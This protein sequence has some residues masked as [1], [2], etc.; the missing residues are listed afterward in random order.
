MGGA[1]GAKAAAGP[2]TETTVVNAEGD[3]EQ[4]DMGNPTPDD[5]EEHHDALD[6]VLR[7]FPVPGEPWVHIFGMANYYSSLLLDHPPPADGEPPI[8]INGWQH[9]SCPGQPSPYRIMYGTHNPA[10]HGVVITNSTVIPNFSWTPRMA[11][12]TK[13]LYELLD[14]GPE[15]L[16]DNVL[17]LPAS[18][19]RVMRLFAHGNV[20]YIA[21]NR[22]LEALP[23]QCDQAVT[24]ALRGVA[25]SSIRDRGHAATGAP[26]R[27]LPPAVLL[28]QC[29]PV[30]TGPGSWSLLV[31][32]G[33]PRTR[34]HALPVQCPCLGW[35]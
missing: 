30:H 20:W 2:S 33:L 29:V 32:R 22:R 31:L 26:L 27:G 23:V 1:R 13:G 6:S 8:L 24:G 25:P 12:E 21:N 35:W 4:P 34:Y 11:L 17:V 16:G 5:D 18:H 9:A 14:A 10:V 3:N 28:P 7:C 15:G 19:G